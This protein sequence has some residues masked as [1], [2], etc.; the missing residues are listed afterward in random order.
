MSDE[1]DHQPGGRAPVTAHY[2]ELNVFGSPTGTVVHVCEG[3][4][5]PA[6]PRSFTD[7]AGWLLAGEA[8]SRTGPPRRAVSGSRSDASNRLR[9]YPGAGVFRHLEL[10]PD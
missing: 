8:S 3:D 6:A 7:T 5:L 9:Y 2:E 10:S 1:E 4:R